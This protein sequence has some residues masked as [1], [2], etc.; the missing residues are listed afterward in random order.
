MKINLVPNAWSIG[1]M[2]AA[3]AV[4]YVRADHRDPEAEDR[5]FPERIRA[6]RAAGSRHARLADVHSERDR[7]VIVAMQG[8]I[9]IIRQILEI[10][11]QA[12][13]PSAPR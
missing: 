6:E 10:A 11:W 7:D 12:P 2:L 1:I 5:R 4:V 3:V 13:A 9:C 8:D